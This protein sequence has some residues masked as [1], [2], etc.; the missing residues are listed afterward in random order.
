[1]KVVKYSGFLAL[2]V[3]LSIGLSGCLTYG[4]VT[5]AKT[6][7]TVDSFYAL[8]GEQQYDRAL[9]FYSDQFIQ[10]TSREAMRQILDNV[11]VS[12]GKYLSHSLVSWQA[13][14]S[15][16]HGSAIQLRYKVHYSLGTTVETLVVGNQG[17][18][19]GHEITY[20]DEYGQESPPIVI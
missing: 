14:L 2:V 13:G 6:R 1:M 18:I 10:N 3:V 5:L 20:T 16:A 12:R 9:D 19:D 4:L 8:I 11:R 17:K 7:K 15:G